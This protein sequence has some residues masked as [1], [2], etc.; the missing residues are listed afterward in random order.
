MTAISD[1]FQNVIDW[2]KPYFGNVEPPKKPDATPP[3][4]SPSPVAPQNNIASGD[5]EDMDLSD[6]DSDDVKMDDASAAAPSEVAEVMNK[7]PAKE[8][9]LVEHL[10]SLL[11]NIQ[12]I[13]KRAEGIVQKAEGVRLE[14]RLLNTV[15]SQFY[16]IQENSGFYD[17]TANK[18]M[19]QQVE[20]VRNVGKKYGIALPQGTRLTKEQ[21][22]AALSGMK[23]IN[24]CLEDDLNKH[25]Q[26]VKKATDLHDELFRMLKS[27]ID[28]HNEI[29]HKFLRAISSKQA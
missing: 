23:R 9:S 10:V 18:A 24:N 20:N 6:D 26:E 16:D 28:K 17:F 27:F 2:A 25:V 4:S 8:A 14:K 1:L 11:H 19:C 7:M 5:P 29:I 21:R 12:L 22:D 3:P 13:K 15:E